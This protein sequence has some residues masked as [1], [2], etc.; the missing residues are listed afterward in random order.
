MAALLRQSQSSLVAGSK[1][2]LVMAQRYAF[3]N[4][5]LCC[6]VLC[7][8]CVLGDGE[9][10]QLMINSKALASA[11]PNGAAGRN[12][13]ETGQKALRRVGTAASL[14]H[15]AASG[16]PGEEPPKEQQQSLGMWQRART[17]GK[18]PPPA[19]D[20]NEP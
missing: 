9:A 8:S 13:T 12:G 16:A 18:A 7:R 10:E 5:C 4:H 14:G 20:V 2:P 11:G 15:Y 17:V 19:D 6:N 3:L 1:S